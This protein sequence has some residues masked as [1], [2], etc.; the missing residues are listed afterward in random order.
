MNMSIALII[1]GYSNQKCQLN[2]HQSLHLEFPIFFPGKFGSVKAYGT[3][4]TLLIR[5]HI[6]NHIFT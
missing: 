5:K 3:F 1:F 6:G 4:L 2:L